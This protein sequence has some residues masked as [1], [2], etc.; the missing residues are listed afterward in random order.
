M[1]KLIAWFIEKTKVGAAVEKVQD[2]LDGKKMYLA[3]AALIVP[4]LIVIIQKFT[5]QGVPYILGLTAT[6]EYKG[7]LE[8]IALC[9]AKAAITKSG[10][11]A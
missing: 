3:G 9:A 6:P 2:A 10:P 7:L 1:N 4:N 11:V 8:G 5:E